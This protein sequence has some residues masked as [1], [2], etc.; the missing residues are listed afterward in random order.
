MVD[1][2]RF[3][4]VPRRRVVSKSSVMVQ[5]RMYLMLMIRCEVVGPY[6]NN[7]LLCVS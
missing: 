7:R 5:H 4:E 3:I 6:E 2:T 1:A